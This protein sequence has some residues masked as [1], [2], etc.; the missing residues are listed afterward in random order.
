M[1]VCVKM[2]HVV[3]SSVWLSVQ[4]GC[5]FQFQLATAVLQLVEPSYGI[6]QHNL[7]SALVYEVHL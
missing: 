3:V 4:F 7:R 6:V 5:Q 1:Q 2:Q